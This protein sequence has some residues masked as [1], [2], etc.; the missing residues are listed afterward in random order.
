MDSKYSQIE[1]RGISQEG[2]LVN[3][4]RKKADVKADKQGR[5]QQ[6]GMLSTLKEGKIMFRQKYNS[7]TR[8]VKHLCKIFVVYNQQ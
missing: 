1:D 7:G 5:I 3:K 8:V 4:D 6:V 2:V